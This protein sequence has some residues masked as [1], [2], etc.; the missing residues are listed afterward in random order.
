MRLTFAATAGEKWPRR[1]AVIYVEAVP[2][3]NSTSTCDARRIGS[4]RADI[5]YVLRR[6]KKKKKTN[7]FPFADIKGSFKR[8]N[9]VARKDAV[10]KSLVATG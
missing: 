5:S 7:V 9:C 6:K 4:D 10:R 2:Y 3:K 8:R 1:F